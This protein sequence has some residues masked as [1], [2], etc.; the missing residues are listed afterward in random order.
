MGM[1]QVALQVRAAWYKSYEY[2]VPGLRH[3]E[4]A[5]R[6]LRRIGTDIRKIVFCRNSGWHALVIVTPPVIGADQLAVAAWRFVDTGMTVTAG[7][8]ESPDR[9]AAVLD[10]YV[11][12]TDVCP[13]VIVGIGYFICHSNEYPCPGEEMRLFFLELLGAYVV[14]GLVGCGQGHF[15]RRQVLGCRYRWNG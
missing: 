15:S 12:A 2:E 1:A 6:E 10:N 8:Q 3:L 4:L 7:I 11:P 13:H 5:Q 9:A 14:Q